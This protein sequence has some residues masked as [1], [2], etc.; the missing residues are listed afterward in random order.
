MKHYYDKK[1]HDLSPL[2]TGQPVHIQDQATKK[3]KVNCTRPEP[4]LYEVKTH[5][6]SILR[7]NRRHLRPADTGQ[8]VVNSEDKSDEPAEASHNVQ[9]SAKPSQTIMPSPARDVGVTSGP[10]C[11]S[12]NPGTYQTRSGRAIRP[13]HFAE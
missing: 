12:P 3:C 2:A 10:P 11:A 9:E 13:A 6:G 8:V 4:R 7:R 1:A 5:S